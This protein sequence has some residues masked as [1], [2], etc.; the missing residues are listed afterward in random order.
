MFGEYKPIMNK[1]QRDKEL[2]LSDLADRW[3]TFTL[4]TFAQCL[5]V[6]Y[7]EQG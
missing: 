6:L 1:K 7:E 3:I 2:F 4:L 5:L